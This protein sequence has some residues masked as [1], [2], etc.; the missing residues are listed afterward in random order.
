[1]QRYR[2][3][4]KGSATE[5]T[6]LNK[7]AQKGWLLAGIKGNWYQFTATTA[8]YRLFSEYVSTEV[9]PTLTSEAAIFEILATVPLKATPKM[10]VIYTGSTQPDIQHARVDQQDAQIQLKIVLGMRAHQLNLMNIA[11]YAG[12]LMVIALI[13]SLGVQQSDTVIWPVIFIW[14]ALIGFRV[15]RAKKLQ[16]VANQLRVRTQNYDGAWKPTMHIFLKKMPADLDVEKVASLGDWMLVGNDK[17]GTYWYDL[18]TLASEAEIRTALKPVL[19]AGVTVYVMSWL[20]LAP[21]G[22]I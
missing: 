19:P 15:L 22:F 14:L 13:F 18:H 21:I 12:L 9:V 1:M 5:L 11:V 8:H 20:G 3:M 2:T 6:W 17:Q 10:Q 4:I 7:M 16:R